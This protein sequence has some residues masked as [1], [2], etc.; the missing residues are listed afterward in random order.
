MNKSSTRLITNKMCPFAQKT[1]IALEAAEVS[2]QLDQ[3]SLYG[4]NGK[5]DWFWEL[6]PQGT[7]PVLVCKSGDVVHADSDE[8][9]DNIGN[10]VDGGS[11]IVPDSEEKMAHA[12]EFRAE[13][14]EFL[15]IGKKAVL[16]GSKDKM[17]KKLKELD[18]LI[19]GPYICGEQVT[20]ADCAG[21]PFLWRI[22]TE[23]GPVEKQGCVNIRSWLDTC[24]SNKAF[25]K[26][27]QSSWW[28]WW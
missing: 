10:S 4:P 18:Q 28:W 9:L 17:W 3:I 12:Q 20:V 7:V 15:P 27:V 25:S 2:Y 14:S 24:K 23:Y 5:P 21:F 6:N 11:K 1:W 26:T 22:D 8:I 13:L 16:G 19:I